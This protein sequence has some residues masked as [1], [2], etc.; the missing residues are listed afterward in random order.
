MLFNTHTSTAGFVA[1]PAINAVMALVYVLV[2]VVCGLSPTNAAI[3]ATFLVVAKL[4]IFAESNKKEKVI[5]WTYFTLLLPLGAVFTND[6]DLVLQTLD[7]ATGWLICYIAATLVAAAYVRE[8]LIAVSK[9]VIAETDAEV[10]AGTDAEVVAVPDAEVVVGAD[11]E[12]VAVP[13]AEVVAETDVEVVAETDAETE[14]EI[15]LDAEEL[16]KIAE[17]L[18]SL[19]NGEDS[20]SNEESK[21]TG[22]IEIS[23]DEYGK[24]A[25]THV[26]SD[27]SQDYISALRYAKDQVSMYNSKSSAGEDYTITGKKFGGISVYLKEESK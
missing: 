17:A 6:D 12:V 19:D 23:I 25:I 22:H 7:A 18:R 14:V 9:A 21:N 15:H 1:T 8:E 4:S 3:T 20:D 10:V 5:L 13:D 11:A 16:A 27:R 26:E 24:A 2:F